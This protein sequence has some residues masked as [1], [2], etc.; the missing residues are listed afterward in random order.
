MPFNRPTLKELA[1]RLIADTES[2]LT[3]TDPRLRR[4]YLNAL[5][6]SSSGAHHELYGFL[7]WIARQA[8]PDTAEDSELD[9]WTRIWGVNRVAATGAAGSVAVT[10]TAATN[11]PA[12]T[13]WQTGDGRRYTSGAAAVVAAAGTVSVDVTA[14]VA[15]VGGNIADQTRLTLTRPIANIQSAAAADGDF[16]GGADEESDD[17]LQ[18]RL[19]FRLKNPPQAGTKEDYERWAREAHS[20]VTRAWTRAIARGLG[21]VDVYMMTDDATANGIPTAAVVA[22]V[23]TYIDDDR[24]P[25][26]ADV[27]A[28]APTPKVLDITIT[29]VDPSTQAVQDAVMAELKDLVTRDTEPGGTLLVSRIR[30]AISTAQGELDHEL[31]TP[32]ADT[33]ALDAEIIVLGA[34]TFAVI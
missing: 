28:I 33:D 17:A 11:I 2:R 22:A 31:T 25:V 9:Q 21:T 6:R 30:E 27:D 16:A 19:L 29:N 26:T 34:V 12:A 23:Q 10:G 1:D 8:F 13:V 7:L 3:G 24:R 4:S 18:A 20:S 15:G 5:T 32:V 14:D